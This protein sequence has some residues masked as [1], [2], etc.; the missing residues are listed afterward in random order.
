MDRHP[1]IRRYRRKRPSTTLPNPESRTI[2]D[3]SS[4]GFVQAYNVQL[5]VDA[6]SQLIVAGLVTN[7]AADS[8]HLLELVAKTEKN[9]GRFPREVSADAGYFGDDNLR[10]LY[11]HEIEGYLAFKKIK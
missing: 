9:L 1:R 3:N 4:K 10:F 6:R 5:A 2:L 7:Q 11:R 8:P